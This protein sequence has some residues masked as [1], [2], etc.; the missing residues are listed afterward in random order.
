[1]F[2]YGLQTQICGAIRFAIAPYALGFGAIRFAIAPCA[3][4]F[5]AIRFAIAPYGL[6]FGAIR[7]AI[8]PYGR[9]GRR[10]VTCHQS[11]FQSNR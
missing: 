4:G 1:M 11:L 7:F 3:L 6:G 8:A 9:Y 10:H 5:G 2:F